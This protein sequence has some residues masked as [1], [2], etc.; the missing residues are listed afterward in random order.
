MYILFGR[1]A[2]VGGTVVPLWNFHGEPN[3]NPLFIGI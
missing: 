3:T 2:E 1:L